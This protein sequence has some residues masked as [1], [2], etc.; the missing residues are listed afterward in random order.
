M[1]S[2]PPIK[3]RRGGDEE[4]ESGGGLLPR[5]LMNAARTGDARVLSRVDGDYA[6]RL[7][8]QGR[9]LLHLAAFWSG[10][11][12]ECLL[13]L[14]DAG[15]DPNARD[16]KQRTPLHEA[17]RGGHVDAAALLLQRG[18]KA[19]ALDADLATPLTLA[20]RGRRGRGDVRMLAVLE[21]ATDPADADTRGRVGA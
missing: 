17:V 16:G 2:L 1:P 10:A 9:S 12:D 19:D 11:H 20:M 15:A 21:A 8:R 4:S 6:T 5:K 13:P 7:D 3:G 14:L 18:A